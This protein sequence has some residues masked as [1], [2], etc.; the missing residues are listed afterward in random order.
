MIFNYDYEYLI[1]LVICAVKGIQPEEKP[2]GISF[3]NVFSLGKIHEVSNIAYL[4]ICA[5]QNKPETKLLEDWKIYYYF[6]AQR[7]ERQ[8]EL[9][10]KTVS[11]LHQNE[12]RTVEAQGTIT[13]TLY[14]SSEMRMMSDIDII[15]DFDN[16]EK[17]KEVLTNSGFS[18]ESVPEQDGELN[19]YDENGYQIELHSEFFTEYIYNR[20]ERF[21]S[22]LN[23]PFEHS[24]KSESDE[25]HYIL[26]ETYYYLYSLLHTLK[27]FETAGCGIR[28]VL[29]L[30]ILKSKLSQK[31][32]NEYIEKVLDEYG[33]SENMNKLYAL[34]ETWFEDKE[35]EEDLS[36]LIRDILNAGNHGSAEVHIKNTILKDK[37]EGIKHPKFAQIKRF[38]LPTKEYIYEEYPICKERGY[39]LNR[40][41][42]YRFA[43]ALSHLNLRNAGERIKSILKAD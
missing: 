28:R 42:L 22:A 16:L 5:L 41:R 8:R 27:H 32:D 24:K 30:Y 7:D 1:H 39:S 14:P 2:E 36:D 3:E 29:D 17:A 19:F 35:T 6:S 9:Y 33:F 26:D 40:A 34:E 11:L 43:F 10:K 38:I 25:Y 18:A 21:F 4:S 13:K 20:K 15:V 12:I 37:S 31:V 23:S